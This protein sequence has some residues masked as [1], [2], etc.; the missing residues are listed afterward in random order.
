M[1]I[2]KEKRRDK[3]LEYGVPA[4]FLDAIDNTKEF[5]DLEFI[6]KYPD[7]VY[8]YLSDIL[9]I[10]EI[11]QGYDVTPIYEG[12]NG[13]T[14][15]VLLSNANETRFV[16]FELENDEIYDDYGSNF[17]LM[18]VDFLIY[19]YESADETSIETLTGYGKKMG[20]PKSAELFK[21]LEEADR[22]DLRKTFE[23]DKQWRRENV[24]RFL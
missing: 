21:S 23:L 9:P 13:D 1:I 20:F 22:V 6:V 8:W 19:Y 10:Y 7:I 15:Y 17:M 5:D 3:L 14:F 12:G 4:T 24:S 2:E 16:H 18:F 11:L